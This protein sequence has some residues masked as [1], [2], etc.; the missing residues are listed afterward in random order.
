MP[1]QIV[2]AVASHHHPIRLLTRPFSAM[3]AVFA[4]NIIAH[5]TR[6]ENGGKPSAEMDLD[7]LKN[8]GLSEHAEEWRRSCL[9]EDEAAEA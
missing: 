7:K 5:E 2:E 6:P 9:A 3:T 8:L 1:Q 4:A